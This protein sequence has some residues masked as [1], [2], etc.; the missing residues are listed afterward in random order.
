MLTRSAYRILAS[1][2]AFVQVPDAHL[3]EGRAPT[4]GSPEGGRPRFTVLSGPKKPNDCFAA[5]CY[6]GYWFWIDDRDMESKRTMMYLMVILALA[7]TGTKEAVP[8]L[9]IQVN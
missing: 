7:D 9:T 4:L 3:T 6:R 2:S 5:V 8:F 1:L